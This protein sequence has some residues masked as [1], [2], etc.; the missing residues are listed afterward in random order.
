VID[1]HIV[2]VEDIEG[3]DRLLARATQLRADK[4]IR[5]KPGR[6]VL[7]KA[8]KVQQDLRF[9]LPTSGRRR[10]TASLPRDWP[11]LASSQAARWLPRRM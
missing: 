7:V 2:A 10:S 8:P 11:A 1:G 5:A 4:R 3:T 9:D 6:G